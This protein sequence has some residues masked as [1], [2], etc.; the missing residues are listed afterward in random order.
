MQAITQSD[1]DALCEDI[2]RLKA[3]RIVHCTTTAFN[4]V[5]SSVE[6]S[7]VK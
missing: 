7:L 6:R 2:A 3:V 4:S 5:L 1:L